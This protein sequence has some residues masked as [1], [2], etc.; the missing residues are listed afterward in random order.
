MSMKF[1]LLTLVQK[2]IGHG[3]I[4]GQNL[5]R[6]LV[7]WVIGLVLVRGGML[8]VLVLEG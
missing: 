2:K 6:V 3:H 1:H 7:H 8:P 4:V 5:L